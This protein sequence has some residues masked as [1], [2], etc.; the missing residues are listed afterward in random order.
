MN[1]Y[2]LILL[3]SLCALVAVAGC[4]DE[5]KDSDEAEKTATKLREKIRTEIKTLAKH[6]WAGE[7]YYGDGLGVNVFLLLAPKAG[8]LFEWHGCLGLYNRNY[9]AVSD[10][11]GRIRLA[12]TFD[13]KGEG[14]QGIAEQFIP[15]PWGQRRYLVSAD[16]IVG[17][18]NAVNAGSEP[19]QH[20]HGSHL[21]RFG[22]EN[23]KVCGFPTVPGGF[24]AYLLERPIE[25]EIVAVGSHRT[26]PSV[27][28]WKFKDF[29]VTLNAGKEHG[30]LPGMKLHVVTRDNIVEAVTITKV[31][32]E[33]S[34][35]VVTLS[36]EEKEAPLVGWRVSTG[37]RWKAEKNE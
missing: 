9:G 5:S 36:G 19:R 3:L 30:L 25:A 12:F 17:F 22:D 2:S 27:L 32:D 4:R 11:N 13:N 35:G 21:L 34:E 37:F 7:Y 16:D 14:A 15:V 20:A 10:T 31:E 26:R 18:C 1:T 6:D 8:Y 23:K 24:K 29:P 28:Q 33:T